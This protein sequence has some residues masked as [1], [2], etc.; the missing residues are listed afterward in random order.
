[1]ERSKFRTYLA[2]LASV[3][4]GFASEGF[5]NVGDGCHQSAYV[6]NSS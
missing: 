5:A 1:M 6:P 2:T 3:S 4:E